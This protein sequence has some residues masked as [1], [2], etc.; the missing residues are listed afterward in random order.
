MR[1]QATNKWWKLGKRFYVT[2]RTLAESQLE[3][4]DLLNNK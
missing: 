1:I 2:S 4:R 3:V